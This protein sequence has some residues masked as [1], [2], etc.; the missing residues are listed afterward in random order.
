M[1]LPRFGGLDPEKRR[2]L[3]DVA[4]ARFAEKGYEGASLNEILAAAGFGKSSYYYYFADKEDLFATVLEDF[5][6]R[7]AVEVPQFSLED[8]DAES[9]WPRI[10]A[11]LA[12]MV[13]T[14]VRY[15][16]MIAIARDIR[17][18][19]RN[20]TPRLRP[21]VDKLVAQQRAHLEIGRTLGTVRTDIDVDWLLAITEAADQAV[22][23]RL[24]TGGELT[25]E[26]LREHTRVVLDTYRRLVE[27]LKMGGPRAP[28]RA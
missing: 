8:L 12:Q 9:F 11:A 22:D 27:P 16:D 3:L 1:P 19:W 14:A 2:Q 26:A 21:I 20:P 7:V 25:A 5:I 6:A 10:E 24:L 17:A 13:A 15:P 4:L 23:E 28:R 18:L